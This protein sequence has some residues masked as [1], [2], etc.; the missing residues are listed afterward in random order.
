MESYKAASKLPL[1][2][3]RVKAIFQ[4]STCQRLSYI[5]MQIFDKM[6]PY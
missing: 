4:I 6:R 3:G 1:K 2:Q 5:F